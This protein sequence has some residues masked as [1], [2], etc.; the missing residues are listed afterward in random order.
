MRAGQ[1]ETR[2]STG[3][4][5]RP[6]NCSTGRAVQPPRISRSGCYNDSAVKTRAT[7]WISGLGEAGNHGN[8]RLGAAQGSA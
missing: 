7:A 3:R 8:L 6:A 1:I 2:P 5:R 4:T